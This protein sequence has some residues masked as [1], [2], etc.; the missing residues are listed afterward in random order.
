M[1]QKSDYRINYLQMT[2]SSD[3]RNKIVQAN[4]I[5]LEQ[6][7]KIEP[8]DNVISLANGNFDKMIVEIE[9]SDQ[10]CLR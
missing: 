6:V 4:C 9:N 1:Y 3:M 5:I 7:C 10:E 2:N 8:W